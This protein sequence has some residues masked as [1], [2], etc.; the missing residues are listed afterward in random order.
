MI[1]KDNLMR[2]NAEESSGFLLMRAIICI[3]CILFIVCSCNSKTRMK[4]REI[5]DDGSVTGASGCSLPAGTMNVEAGKAY[6]Q[7]CSLGGFPDT[8]HYF[9]LSGSGTLPVVNVTLQA[10][11]V[12][13]QGGMYG[14]TGPSATAYLSFVVLPSALPG[15]TRSIIIKV[16]NKLEQEECRSTLVLTLPIMLINKGNSLSAGDKL[17]AGHYLESVNGKYR[18]IM[19]GDGNV[20]LYRISSMEA[21][22]A[23]GTCNKPVSTC[24]LTKSGN[25]VATGENGTVY[26]QTNT[27]A[28]N[29]QPVMYIQDDGNLVIYQ[30]SPYKAVWASGTRQP[31]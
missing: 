29:G 28:P 13:S 24:T 19:Q 14:F 3:A 4:S 25:L 9:S 10:D 5:I 2:G 26:W 17:L 11:P 12:F 1:T 22:W 7:S 31:D 20:V 30:M 27:T 8:A 21:L 18:F 16:Y 15:Q 23:A 6:Y